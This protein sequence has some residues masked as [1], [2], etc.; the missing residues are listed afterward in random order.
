M[1]DG[2]WI[3]FG[4][5]FPSLLFDDFETWNMLYLWKGWRMDEMMVANSHSGSLAYGGC[6]RDLDHRIIKS[7]SPRVMI[8]RQD[9]M[10]KLG[11]I[12]GC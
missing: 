2:G 9:S 7:F 11:S 5:I 4:M 10:K 12:C 6:V 3:P 8:I 1:V